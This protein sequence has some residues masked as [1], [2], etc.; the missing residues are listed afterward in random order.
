MLQVVVALLAHGSPHM[1][2]SR[3]SGSLG[4]PDWD[5]PCFCTDAIVTGMIV[6]TAWAPCLLCILCEGIA[7]ETSEEGSHYDFSLQ[8]P[9]SMHM[10]SHLKDYPV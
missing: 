1:Q 3:M 2:H 9:E 4:W 7:I 8:S 5:K 10:S 6:C